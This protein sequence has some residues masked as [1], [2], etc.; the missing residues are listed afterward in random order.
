MMIVR[1]SPPMIDTLK[2]EGYPVP[3]GFNANTKL[4]PDWSSI[5]EQIRSEFSKIEDD[6]RKKL[7]MSSGDA[8]NGSKLGGG[9]KWDR[10]KKVY[11]EMVEECGGGMKESMTSNKSG[12]HTRTRCIEQRA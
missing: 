2:K 11:D 6:A 12:E 1:M 10:L 3:E 8:D 5:E 7:R 9:M 4:V